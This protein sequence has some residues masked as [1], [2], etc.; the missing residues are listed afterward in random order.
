MVTPEWHMRGPQTYSS[1]SFY[2][3]NMELISLQFSFLVI[4]VTNRY[5]IDDI[6]FD[7]DF[8]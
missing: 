6:D 2:T 5:F 3:A 8:L 1:N 7:F 4:C